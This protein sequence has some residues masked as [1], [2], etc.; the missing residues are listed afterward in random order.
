M[1]ENKKEK[2]ISKG[3]MNKRV[4]VFVKNLA[5]HTVVYTGII[6]DADE[7]FI[8]INDRDGCNFWMNIKDVVQIK[9]EEINDKIIYDIDKEK[10]LEATN[11]KIQIS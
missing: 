3:W 4:K 11:G 1:K 8:L 5:A 6:T 7:N 2:K 9:E 10:W